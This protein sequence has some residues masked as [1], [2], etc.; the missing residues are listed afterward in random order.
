LEAWASWLQG[1]L[2]ISFGGLLKQRLLAGSL[3]MDTDQI[4]H[5]GVGQLLSRVLESE[6]L[7]ALSL[8]GGAATVLSA[9]EL[10]LAA[11]VLA[12]G[13][14]REVTLS[15]FA[16]WLVLVSVV[17]WRYSRCR[18]E[19]MLQRNH[20]THDLVE[21]MNGHRT[22]IAQQPAELWH[23]GEDRDLLR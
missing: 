21:K 2:A 5:Q 3:E 23:D 13:A 6:S 9:V 18:R 19:W 7:E 11:V 4:R 17:A 15:L 10:T 12:I 1:W 16:G 14:A 20:L 22:R 8:T